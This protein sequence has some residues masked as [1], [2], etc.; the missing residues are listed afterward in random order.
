MAVPIV[1]AR[2]PG[3][4]A[5]PIHRPPPFL[6]PAWPLLMDLNIPP[7]QDAG[8]VRVG[9]SLD[10]EGVCSPGL[11]AVVN[12]DGEWLRSRGG[13][14]DHRGRAG[15]RGVFASRCRRAGTARA[16]DNQRV[17]GLGL[18]RYGHRV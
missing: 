6:R 3:A 18:Y 13:R 8:P 7:D 10:A 16:A 2:L 4:E 17:H 12:L 11:A 9:R 15:E 5:E 1:T 14:P